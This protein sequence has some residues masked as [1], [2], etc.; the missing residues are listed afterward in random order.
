MQNVNVVTVVQARTGSSRLPKKVLM[1][2]CEEPLL[3]RMLERVKAAETIGTLV[4]ATSENPEDD[5]IEEMCRENGYNIFRGHLTD[6]LDRHY[7]AGLKYKADAVVKI[8]SDCPLIDPR[9]IDKVIKV[10][11]DNYDKYDYVSNLHPASFPDGNDV[12]IM[13]FSVLEEAHKEAKRNL[14]REHTTP[15]IWERPERFACKNVIFKEDIDFSSSHRWTIDYEEDYIFIRSVFE[16]L[17]HQ[18][19]MF[20]IYDILNLLEEKPYL[21]DINKKYSGSYWYDNHINELNNIDEY[22]QKKQDQQDG[23]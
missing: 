21:M 1:S 2:V 23:R 5:V 22:K 7:Q 6:L 3:L 20:S 16:E 13:K 18:N 9:V 4:V 8:P 19:K 10:F 15:F 17:Y 11:L 14:E 12:E